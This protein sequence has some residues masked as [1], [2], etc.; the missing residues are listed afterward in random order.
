VLLLGILIVLWTINTR[1][2]ARVIQENMTSRNFSLS[3]K[4]GS[5]LLLVAAGEKV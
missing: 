1:S 3:L 5:D 4:M 2:N